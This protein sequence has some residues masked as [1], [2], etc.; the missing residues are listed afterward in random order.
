[1]LF[2]ER[3]GRLVTSRELRGGVRLPRLF[4][5]EGRS[6]F[7]AVSALPSRKKSP[8]SVP[9]NR[10]EP[11]ASHRSSKCRRFSLLRSVPR[12]HDER[13]NSAGQTVL[14]RGM[15]CSCS[16]S[17]RGWSLHEDQF[18]PL[19]ASTFE[20]TQCLGVNRAAIRRPVKV[21][22]SAVPLQGAAFRDWI[23]GRTRIV[24]FTFQR[25]SLNA[26]NAERRG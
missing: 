6:K 1:M 12:G 5:H 21:S 11:L 22:S 13:L 23:I 17:L 26:R 10:P 16:A 4:V 18:H 15:H 19:H 9:T 8:G 3:P 25:V 20:S 14:G 7:S 2:L 24:L